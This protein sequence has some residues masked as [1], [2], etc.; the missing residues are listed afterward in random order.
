[1]MEITTTGEHRQ[2]SVDV[3]MASQNIFLWGDIKNQKHAFHHPAK[4]KLLYSTGILPM[5]R[6]LDQSNES[7]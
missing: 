1:M 5:L 3:D 2:S 4:A 7:L 6:F